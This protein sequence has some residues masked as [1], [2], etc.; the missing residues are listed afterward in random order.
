MGQCCGAGLWLLR[1]VSACL[2]KLPRLDIRVLTI[3]S[4]GWGDLT[5]A[6]SNLVLYVGFS[7]AVVCHGYQNRTL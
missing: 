7:Y 3:A 2:D 5:N 1:R 4:Y 6:H